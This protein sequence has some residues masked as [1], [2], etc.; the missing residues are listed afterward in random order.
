MYPLVK[1]G[2]ETID[3]EKIAKIREHIDSVIAIPPEA[4]IENKER[5]GEFSFKE[6]ERDSSNTSFFA[7]FK[8]IAIALRA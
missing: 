5:W 8:K 4:Y 1:I 2:V 3:T 7:T 6:G